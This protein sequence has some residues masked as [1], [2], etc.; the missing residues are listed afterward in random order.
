[1]QARCRR[2]LIW[3]VPVLVAL[4]GWAWA[5]GAAAQGF[6]AA[7]CAQGNV[8]ALAMPEWAQE[9]AAPAMGTE[10]APPAAPPT[11]PPATG[12]EPT[13]PEGPPCTTNKQCK[14]PKL[15]CAKAP[16]HCKGKG[17]CEPKPEICTKI[18]K[19][20]CG[21]NGRTYSNACEAA[22]KGINVRHQGKCKA[23][24]PAEPAAAKSTP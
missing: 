18:Y 10:A 1:M 11:A 19:P 21:C 8:A 15:Y 16:G 6:D 9:P 4:A 20:V 12:S 14:D 5:P 7:P 13:K 17:T 22:A 23:K 24:K 3:V 2:S